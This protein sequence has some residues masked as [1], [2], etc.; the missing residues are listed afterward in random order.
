MMAIVMRIGSNR[1]VKQQQ[2]ASFEEYGYGCLPRCDGGP[3]DGLVVKLLLKEGGVEV[4]EEELENV[5]SLGR[6][7]LCCLQSNRICEV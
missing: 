4:V 7:V 2:V 3:L 5:M 1:R 6:I